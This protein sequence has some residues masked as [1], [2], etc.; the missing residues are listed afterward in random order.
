V[1][2]RLLALAAT[3]AGF[4]LER[5]S[6]GVLLGDAIAAGREADYAEGTVNITV[7]EA[8]PNLS[9]RVGP[10]VPGG[11]QRML[12]RMEMPEY[13]VSLSKLASRMEVDSSSAGDYLAIEVEP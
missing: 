7:E 12:E 3:R 1:I 10:F 2:A 13:G 11:G 6:E 8:G 9:M 5:M 4:S